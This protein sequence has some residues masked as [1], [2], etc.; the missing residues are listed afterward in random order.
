MP[1]NSISSTWEPSCRSRTS[2]TVY[3]SQEPFESFQHRVIE[4][5]RTVLGT[6]DL[7]VERLR[8]NHRVVLVRVA[9]REYVLRVPRWPDISMAHDVAPLELLSYEEIPAPSVVT[10]DIGSANALGRPYMIQQRIPG[11]P[12][13]NEYPNSSHE[14]KCII[15]R[16]LGRVFSTM[17]GIR[18][19]AAGRLVWKEEILWL[20]AWD[21]KRGVI[22]LADVAGGDT[23]EGAEEWILRVLRSRHTEAVEREMG[24]RIQFFETLI[25]IAQGMGRLGMWQMGNACCL[26]HRDLEPRNILV[27]QGGITGILDWDRTV[28]G[29]L[30][31][32]CSPPMWL[33]AWN[34]NGPEDLRHVGNAPST[35]EARE[36]KQLFE[37]GAAAGPIYAFFAYEP[38]CRLARQLI[39][40][41]VSCPHST[42]EWR[43]FDLFCE[44]WEVIEREREVWIVS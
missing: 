16:D 36:L 7:E 38:Q 33:W 42:V 3:Y 21:P 28:F 1:L 2:S 20:E 44:E 9:G 19:R 18:S 17:H 43:E 6:E 40:W 32:S 35:P 14:T 13:L 5:C 10:F 11:R 34:D 29:P 25:I 39:R 31:L 24:Y 37:A 8:G 23:E 27:S 26:C 4:L 41:M 15:A 30:L 12:L 22:A